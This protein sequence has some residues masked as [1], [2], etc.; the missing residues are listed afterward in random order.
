VSFHRQLQEDS[1][2]PHALLAAMQQAL[3]QRL[4]VPS[5]AVP[6]A[7]GA[8]SG[9][10][11]RQEGVLAS[12]PGYTLNAAMTLLLLQ[13][14]MPPNAMATLVTQH[15]LV[16]GDPAALTAEAQAAGLPAQV[17]EALY[18][19]SCWVQSGL[20]SDPDRYHTTRQQQE[21]QQ[22][23]DGGGPLQPHYNYVWWLCTAL[24]HLLAWLQADKQL[25]P[26][27]LALVDPLLLL[28][29]FERAAVALCCLTRRL[30][31]VVLPEYLALAGTAGA[32]QQ[33][34]YSWL[35]TTNISQVQKEK[36]MVGATGIWYCGQSGQHAHVW[37]AC[38][39]GAPIVTRCTKR[40]AH[41]VHRVSS[42]LR[43]TCPA[44]PTTPA[45]FSNQMKCPSWQINKCVSH[46]RLAHWDCK[47]IPLPCRTT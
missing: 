38:R 20:L 47:P 9:G 5:S 36:L 40:N 14:L 10:G 27:R 18:V 45:A 28:T 43:A 37:C 44:Q 46:R 42:H 32:G 15:H 41:C 29:L 1:S 8:W 26:A 11:Y 33:Q 22:E 2:L 3:Q 21:Q 31:N 35:L 39:L 7:A 30:H 16:P 6:A 25:L 12:T 34:L 17:M 13:P 23:Q 19:A 24:R 4:F